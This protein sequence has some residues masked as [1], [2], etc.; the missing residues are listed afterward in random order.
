MTPLAQMIVKEFLLSPAQRTPDPHGVRE[1]LRGAHCF[2]LS[3]VAEDLK[4]M[5]AQLSK[6]GVS[7]T[8]IFLPADVTFIELRL[9]EQVIVGL[10]LG[11]SGEKS[12]TLTAVR[13]E[14][15][16]WRSYACAEFQHTGFG[17]ARDALEVAERDALVKA[18]PDYHVGYRY[19]LS[20]LAIINSPRV[21]ER[22][23]HMPH[24][25]L[26]KALRARQKL[27]GKFPLHAWTEITLRT[28]PAVNMRDAPSQEAHL[29][30]RRPLH[31]CRAH[32]RVRNGFPQF[33]KAHWRGDPAI[34][35][36]RSRYRLA[37][38]RQTA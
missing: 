16:G 19:L 5:S 12:S 28:G 34:G 26:E 17:P 3:A 30:G 18:E 4:Y 10:L 13:R 1:R 7:D 27:I 24:R 15:N 38:A 32:L 8:L 14:P 2:E 22:K 36:K 31:F 35:I 25:G 11:R 21:V 9:S 29:T 37:P 33:V 23:Q 6:T 20:A